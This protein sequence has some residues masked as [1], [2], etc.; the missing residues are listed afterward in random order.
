MDNMLITIIVGI[1]ALVVG[2]LLAKLLEKS[3]ASQL[4]K[5]AKKKFSLQIIVILLYVML[6]ILH[7]V[8]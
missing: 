6:L 4:I 8:E 5:S 7:R 2:F 3:N 1:I